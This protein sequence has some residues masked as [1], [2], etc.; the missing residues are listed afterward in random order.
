VVDAVHPG[1]D[2]NAVQRAL[3]EWRQPDIAVM[4]QR[5]ELKRDLVD[6]VRRQ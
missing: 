1:C 4:E 5:A 3:E 2:Q 6:Y